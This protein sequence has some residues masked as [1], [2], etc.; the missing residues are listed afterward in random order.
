MV[1]TKYIIDKAVL[2]LVTPIYQAINVT[3]A[4]AMINGGITPCTIHASPTISRPKHLPPNTLFYERSNTSSAN[5]MI[6]FAGNVS[7]KYG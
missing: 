4:R 1:Y 7:I 5:S 2:K 6:D 3:W